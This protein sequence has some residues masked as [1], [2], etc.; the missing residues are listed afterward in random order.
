M[1]KKYTSKNIIQQVY[2]K[3]ILLTFFS[4]I[5]FTIIFAAQEILP[6]FIYNIGSC[7]LYIGIY[8]LTLQKRFRTTVLL[9]HLEICAFVAF[10]CIYAGWDC[11]FALYLLALSALVYFCPFERKYIP[12]LLSGMEMILFLILKILSMRISPIHHFSNQATNSFYIFNALASFTLILYAAVVT[13]LSAVMTEDVLRRSNTRLQ[14]LV[15]HDTLTKLWSRRHLT[16]AF[17]ETIHKENPVSIVLT[18]IDNFKKINDTYGHDCGDYILSEL[19]KLLKSSCPKETGICR[20]GGEEFVFLFS[21]ENPD[22]VVPIIEHIRQTVEK[23]PF[24]YE[25]QPLNITMTFGISNSTEAT[26]LKELIRLAD[27]RMYYGKKMGK[28]TVITANMK[29]PA[30]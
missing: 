2:G 24:K 18:D 19:G 5:L 21:H 4:H 6:L 14:N 15:D 26:D 13:K 29:L 9:T 30:E 27:K 20:W 3:V 7:L 16:D 25:K 17:Q 1:K 10:S 23:Y 11:G 8:I 28:N 22:A 12:Y